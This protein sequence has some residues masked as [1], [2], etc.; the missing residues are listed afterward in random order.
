[1]SMSASNSASCSLASLSRSLTIASLSL[2]LCSELDVEHTASA[3]GGESGGN[4]VVAR[5]SGVL[6]DAE[7]AEEDDDDDAP[8]ASCEK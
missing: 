7:E 4:G 6:P 2:L 1:M 3:V 8:V 5:G